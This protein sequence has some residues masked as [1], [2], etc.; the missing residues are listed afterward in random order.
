MLLI[1]NKYNIFTALKLNRGFN[2]SRSSFC[3][4]CTNQ[5]ARLVERSRDD[6][7]GIIS[8]YA[9]RAHI[10]CPIYFFEYGK[11]I[12]EAQFISTFDL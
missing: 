4:W 1:I 11:N 9:N 2:K 10:Q 3:A 7:N 5:R 8:G 12:L 6:E